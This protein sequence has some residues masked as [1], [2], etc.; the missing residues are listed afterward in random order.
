MSKIESQSSASSYKDA[1][2]LVISQDSRLG[3]V[4]PILAP[5]MRTEL[6]KWSSNLGFYPS[7]YFTE[8][9]SLTPSRKDISSEEED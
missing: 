2:A 5:N 7:N 9:D 4:P 6:I 3:T 1:Q 8:G